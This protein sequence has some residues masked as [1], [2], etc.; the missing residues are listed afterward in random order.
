MFHE[1]EA[2]FPPERSEP[3]LEEGPR[4]RATD[5]LYALG[6][7]L[8]GVAVVGMAIYVVTGGSRAREQEPGIAVGMAVIQLL[9]EAWLGVLVVLLARRRGISLR[10]L[11]FRRP[12]DWNLTG[13]AVAGA[14]GA[15]IGY[16]LI[17]MALGAATHTD[18]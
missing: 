5:L 2:P 13:F 14:Y 10:A 16:T 8:L 3:S 1:Y 18:V 7:V 17:V 9:F 4:W 15:I 12:R 6:L 11:G